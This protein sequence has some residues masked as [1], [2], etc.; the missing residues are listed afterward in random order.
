MIF[1]SFKNYD[2]SVS[3][4]FSIRLKKKGVFFNTPLN[5]KYYEQII[6]ATFL[7]CLVVIYKL[8]LPIHSPQ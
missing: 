7:F 1:L 3:I 2:N 8:D 6:T 5:Y 4:I